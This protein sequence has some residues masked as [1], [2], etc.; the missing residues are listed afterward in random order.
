M[1][2]RRS[3]DVA[4]GESGEAD[5]RYT[6]DVVLGY[7]GVNTRW[8]YGLASALWNRGFRLAARVLS[9]IVRMV[10]GVEIHPAA[11]IGR[12]C[13][14]DHGAG[15]VIGE[16]AEI[17]DDVL[18]YHGCT[19]GGDANHRG[20][21]H[22][23]IGD[24]VVLGANATLI[25]AISVGDGA[26]VGVRIVGEDEVRSSLPRQ[27]EGEVEGTGLFRA[28]DQMSQS[29]AGDGHRTSVQKPLQHF[30]SSDR[31]S[32][33]VNPLL[34]SGNLA[35]SRQVSL[36]VSEPHLAAAYDWYLSFD[37]S[38]SLYQD[39]TRPKKHYGRA[40]L[41]VLIL[42]AAGGASRSCIARAA[43]PARFGG[44]RGLEP[45]HAR[46]RRAAL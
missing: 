44:A 4:A 37:D 29:N 3:E 16:T 10:T 30:E 39:E 8:M 40:A 9:T 5:D 15:V 38:Y 35:D 33:P 46:P 27:A 45:D 21:R 2:G 6:R 36:G 14:I 12:R 7:P 17:G 25:G 20:K 41:E 34:P 18:M 43:G 11:E 31:T 28:S 24:D 19:L 26:A 23:T 1:V 42:L 22:P 13:V 32:R